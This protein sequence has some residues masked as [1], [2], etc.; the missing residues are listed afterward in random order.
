MVY[1]HGNY[2]GPNWSGGKKQGSIPYGRMKAVDDFDLSAKFHDDAYATW[3]KNKLSKADHIFYKHNIGKGAVRTAAALA[4]KAQGL[5]R[6]KQAPATPTSL[7]KRPR[8]EADEEST[9]TKKKTKKEKRN[10][11]QPP[12]NEETMPKKNGGKRMSKRSST[13]GKRRANK[14]KSRRKNSLSFKRVK[15]SP[16]VNINGPN[17]ASAMVE[18]GRDVENVNESLH[19]GHHDA[20][21]RQVE[22]VMFLAFV[23][24][25][26]HKI[27]VYPQSFWDE[28]DLSKFLGSRFRLTVKTT[29]AASTPAS[30]IDIDLVVNGTDTNYN[31]FG[32][33]WYLEYVAQLDI[34][35]RKPNTWQFWEMSFFPGELYGYSKVVVSLRGARIKI[36]TNSIL[37]IQ[38]QTLA[39]DTGTV[40]GHATDRVDINP[41]IGKGYGGKGN[42]TLFQA[43]LNPRGQ[44]SGPAEIIATADNGIINEI[45]PNNGLQDPLPAYFY[46]SC[47][48][49]KKHVKIMPGQTIKSYLKG[50]YGMLADQIFQKLY[51]AQNNVQMSQIGKF[52]FYHLEREITTAD[53]NAKIHIAFEHNFTVGVKVILKRSLVTV[54]VFQQ[55]IVLVNPNA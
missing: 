33:R 50:S 35:G 6:G 5:L 7:K 8:E 41:L 30:Y 45:Q 20:P 55:N 22:F 46:P 48:I 25:M 52:K 37:R 21:A 49:E 40:G 10:S 39:G 15:R 44:A 43:K 47:K 27:G 11:A 4:V 24:T 42:G 19:I 3:P 29:Y 18:F 23:K 14:S 9:P 31:I 53:N 28:A 12:N 2:V 36:L 51:P 17:G 26:L 34:A 54:P 13:S 16:L 1:I 32:I 38:N